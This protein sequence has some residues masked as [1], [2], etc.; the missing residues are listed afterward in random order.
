VDTTKTTTHI[1]L[2][3]GY[4]GIELGL[5]RIIP[6]LRSVALCEIEAYA[7]A[8]LVAKM[9]AGLMEPAPIWTDLKTFPW[10]SFRDRVDILTGGY[11]C[12][13]FSA[14]GKRLGTEDPR[15][16]W[17]FIAS[18]IR[19]LRPR[20]CFFEN[21]EGHISLGLREV[22]GELESMGYKVSWG[23][24]S[25]REVG[26][27]HQRKRVF[28][29]AH[30][31][32]EGLEGLYKWYTPSEQTQLVGAD[33]GASCQR[34]AWEGCE[35]ANS[36]SVKQRA[37]GLSSVRICGFRIQEQERIQHQSSNC[38]KG[39][40]EIWPSRPG[41]PQHGW[42]PPRVVGNSKHNGLPTKQIIR[43]NEE[44][45]DEWREE[46]PK[47]ARQLEGADRSANVPSIQGCTSRSELANSNSTQPSEGRGNNG[48]VPQVPA[49]EWTDE[50]AALSGGEGEPRGEEV[51][52]NSTTE[53]L[54]GCRAVIEMDRESRGTEGE[55]SESA[56]SAA[57]S[58]DAHGGEAMGN[59][60][61][62]RLQR[63][64]QPSAAWTSTNPTSTAS[65]TRQAEPSMGG[66]PDGTA[67]RL[68]YAQ[69]CVT[70]DNRTDELRLLGNGVVP[71]TAERAFR[72][73]LNELNT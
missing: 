66:N 48:E 21:V 23:I 62:E 43:S 18:G 40:I 2:C 63:R 42:E 49:G 45:S 61:S 51:L 9:E 64:E 25:A 20:L 13:P 30:L 69:L 32:C 38:G 27:P 67:D 73:L 14:A 24:F 12:Q 54:Q 10:E 5:K 71:A 7:C 53:G 56:P 28:I 17:P 55:G 47:Q 44:T 60:A 70:C 16:L 72:T 52:G 39:S 58:S 37:T 6:N 65:R 35:L 31:K 8:N 22:V 57:F 11:P 59:A 36:S 50:C 1:G 34:S 3:A 4:G 46:E 29:M 33:S 19:L 26:A 41:E 15:H 68:D